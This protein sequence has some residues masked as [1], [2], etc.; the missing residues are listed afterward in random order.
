MMRQ[1]ISKEMNFQFYSRLATQKDTQKEVEQKIF[2]F[3][4]RLAE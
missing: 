3:Y 1:M 4:S 2:Q